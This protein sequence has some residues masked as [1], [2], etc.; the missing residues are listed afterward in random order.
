MLISP[1]QVKRSYAPGEPVP[2]AGIYR[3]VHYQH[4]MPHLVTLT[5]EA[6]F[7][8]DCRRCNDKV[9][10][11][12]MFVVTGEHTSASPKEFAPL[13]SRDPDLGNAEAAAK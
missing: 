2:D 11:E 6:K 9:S 13:Y 4:R 1:D 8:P 7:F 5:A 3:V 10:F 12:P